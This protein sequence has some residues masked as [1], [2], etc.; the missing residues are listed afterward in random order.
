M[1]S[2]IIQF[3]LKYVPGA[4]LLRDSWR[5]IITSNQQK[6]EFEHLSSK[7]KS[8]ETLFQSVGINNIELYCNV[9][10][11]RFDLQSHFLKTSKSQIDQDLFVLF[12]LQGKV[13]GFFVEFG[14]TNGV[15]FSNTYLL[16]KKFNWAGIL[17]EPGKTWHT[18]LKKNRNCKIDKRCVYN[19]SGKTLVFA[20]S[21]E[22]TLSTI[23]NF[24][25]CD[26][27]TSA[28]NKNK[29]YEVETVSLID[30]LQAN[31]APYEIDYLSVDT[32]GSELEILSA[33][34]FSMYNI[35]IITVEHNYTANREKIHK[36]LSNHG[37]KRVFEEYS[38]FGD[39]YVQG[40]ILSSEKAL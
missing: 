2:K 29:K 36:L 8:W 1:V 40:G 17:A 3:A 6:A 10:S 23:E 35:R 24:V 13:N 21:V 19:S 9:L 39:W 31:N 28:R 15:D 18:D 16:E 38:Y 33:F 14:A 37:F 5:F 25:S 26:G 34:D 7:I 11:K 12:A 32:E 27:H 30:L 22:P 4:K 20:D